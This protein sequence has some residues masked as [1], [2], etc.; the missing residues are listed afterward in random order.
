[1]T[2][3]KKQEEYVKI[4]RNTFLGKSEIR[5]VKDKCREGGGKTDA[6]VLYGN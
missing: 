2:E 6:T 4:M 3:W 5:K 1:M